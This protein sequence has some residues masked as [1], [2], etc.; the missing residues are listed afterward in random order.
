[1]IVALV[2]ARNLGHYVEWISPLPWWVPMTIG[3]VA[4]A[5]VVTTASPASAWLVLA[6]CLAWGGVAI[7]INL[8]RPTYT[9]RDASAAI[10]A[11]TERGDVIVGTFAHALAFANATHPVWYTPKRRYNQLLNQDLGRFPVRWVLTGEA[12]QSPTAEHYPF[13]LTPV[14]GFDLLPAPRGGPKVH[15]DLYRRAR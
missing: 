15:V 13:P 3:V 11:R 4:V 8:A 2:P 12:S 7:G 14:A 9:L 10:G 6:A 1:M 5:L